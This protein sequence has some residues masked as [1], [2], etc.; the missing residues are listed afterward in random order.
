MKFMN[1]RWLL[2]LSLLIGYPALAVPII[3]EFL[4]NP[5]AEAL[6]DEDGE[7]EDWVEIFN[8]E[9]EP[10]D[11]EGYF[12]TD[13]LTLEERW[14][15]PAGVTLEGNGYLV[16]FAS[17]KDRANAAGTLH[18]NFKLNS[19]EDHLILI[20]PDGET[21]LSSYSWDAQTRQ[22]D[23]VSFGK[24]ADLNEDQFFQ[25]PS[26]G[27]VNSGPFVTPGRVMFDQESQAFEGTLTVALSS[28][29]EEVEI[30]Y[31]LDGS[32][33]TEE[34]LL[35]VEPIVLTEST[36][37]RAR[38]HGASLGDV[39]ARHYV[40]LSGAGISSRFRA[41]S[42]N[43]AGF[44]SDL[45]IVIIDSFA[46]RDI[47]RTNL[48]KTTVSLFEPVD[49]V[50][51][52]SN[53]ATI[54][55]NA[56]I[57]IRGQSSAN[58]G[59]KQYRIET[60]NQEDE[61]KDVSFLGLPSDS[62][63]VFGAPFTDKSLIRNSLLFDL[64]RDLG[65]SAPRTRHVEVFV[66]E[67][68]GQLNYQNHYKGVYVITEQI[69]I[70]NDRVDIAELSPGDM[71]EP[72]ISGGYLMSWEADGA[73][74]AENV[75]PGWSGLELRDPDPN[76]QATN[77][78]KQ[79]IS[80]YMQEADRAI[81]GADFGD[82]NL[83]Y[84]RYIDLPS[85]LNLLVINELTR[86]Q[87]AY[88]R[89]SYLYKDRGGKIIQGPLWDYNLTM[90][91]GCCRNNRNITGNGSF[92]AFSNSV[93]S[94]WQWVENHAKSEHKWE[95]RLLEDA[96]FLQGFTDR[97]Q[98]LR[99]GGALT[100]E[101][102]HRRLFEQ[103]APLKEG[104]DRNFRKW[105]NLNTERVGFTTPR[106]I[107]WEEQLEFM[108]NWT[109][110]R[111]QWIDS[112]FTTSPRSFPDSGEM[113][114]GSAAFI[115]GLA[116][117]V[118]YTVDGSDPRLEGGLVNPGAQNFTVMAGEDLVL[119]AED[120][121]GWSYLDD[122]S[123][124]GG[125]DIVIG[126]ASYDMSHWKH[127]GFDDSG[128]ETGVAPLGYARGETTT[129]S[130]GDDASMKHLSY[131]FRKSFD[132]TD[133]SSLHQLMLEVQ[134]DDGAIVYLNG[135]EV[136]RFNMPSGKVTFM[137][138]ASSSRRASGA[139][140]WRLITIDPSLVVSGE[141]VVALQLHQFSPSNSDLSFNL[142][143]RGQVAGGLSEMLVI[144]ET[145]E[146]KA[147]A[148]ADGKWSALEQQVYV[149]GESARQH[150]LVISEVHYHPLDV[151]AAEEAAGFTN[152]DDFEFIE[153]LNTT[154]EPLELSGVSFTRGI[155]FSFPINTIVGAGERIVVVSN[156]EAFRLRYPEVAEETI[157]G[158]F[159]NGSNLSNS[160]ETIVLTGLRGETLH[161]FTYN[162]SAPWPEEADGFGRSLVLGL[163]YTVPNH[164]LPESWI[165]G[166]LDQG[167]PASFEGA[168][169]PGGDDD[170]LLTYATGNIPPVVTQ[171]TDG[172]IMVSIQLNED[173]DD[174]IGQL[175]QSTNLVDWESVEDEFQNQGMTRSGGMTEVAFKSRT[176]RPLGQM[177]LRYVVFE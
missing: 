26:P 49:G 111:M 59:K 32:L 113:T 57:R 109:S 70:S 55:T 6:V 5:N 160:G 127:P 157:M 96:D 110:E 150:R 89:S 54:S 4:A 1:G 156:E 115:N 164:A 138:E 14:E 16:I 58:F 46:D 52:F 114:S 151:S 13:D 147:R 90:G 128:W 103:A 76:E 28:V 162:D 33:P 81:K 85:H 161:E 38:L 137:T 134:C 153:L 83:G 50:A 48:S 63:W 100:D 136:G 34:S 66:N 22:L 77:A 131:Y 152:Q 65:L 79:W 86:D 3:S 129:I 84:E 19:N 72:D 98:G 176:G 94:G 44:T 145:T 51:S 21:I 43:L 155:E 99:D 124:Q 108:Q 61:D 122:G 133:P 88:I 142:R 80:N 104:A 78:Q 172:S 9:S 82:P 125:S 118:Y 101:A 116:G 42:S 91:N 112:Q 165:T 60:R 174:V 20:A 132:F 173:A 56:G 167:T 67:G 140:Q 87:D 10:L 2:I 97:W 35:Y 12:L 45:P 75:L 39:S 154:N 175:Q 18:T 7:R 15:I 68:G 119:I 146:V 27:A 69:K 121:E 92:T 74:T 24:V 166:S 31:T 169:F 73:S 106:T 135:Q 144:N 158:E 107:T 25:N 148:L 159:E 29:S 30:R 130:F 141:N 17:G 40:R 171:D 93:D 95:S 143:L 123:D 47:D 64:G 71:A 62:D 37:I 149:V 11:L 163:P 139:E 53:P 41:G 8:P 23:G 120:S 105:S 126:E 36:M 168:A 177:F 117:T 102:F 170:A